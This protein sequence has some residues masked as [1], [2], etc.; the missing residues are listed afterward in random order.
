MEEVK[1]ILVV[2]G[3]TESCRRAI[4]YGCSLARR[5]GAELAV[6]HMVRQNPFELSGGRVPTDTVEHDYEVYLREA[7]EHLDRVTVSREGGGPSIRRIA[8]F[9]HPS[10]EIAKLVR[11]ERF[12]L[13]VL[14]ARP[15][16]G[17]GSHPEA[18]EVGELVRDLPCSVLLVREERP[19]SAA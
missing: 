18:R 16:G 15:E 10:K 11:E 9:G 2:S 8:R 3:L 14:P 17:L 12:D 1:R 19:P 7:L 4:R 13:V 5:Y 6:V